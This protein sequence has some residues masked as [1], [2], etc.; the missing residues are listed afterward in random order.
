MH[1]YAELLTY[2]NMTELLILYWHTKINR[3]PV[4]VCHRKVSSSFLSM[5]DFITGALYGNFNNFPFLFFLSFFSWTLN[6]ENVHLTIP[7]S[8][9][10]LTN[11]RQQ[12]FLGA[13]W[14]KMSNMIEFLAWIIIYTNRSYLASILMARGHLGHSNDLFQVFFF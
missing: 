4:V 10:V 9:N 11:L 3:A 6:L 14:P 12:V 13:F 2:E 1:T 7:D 5:G 8:R